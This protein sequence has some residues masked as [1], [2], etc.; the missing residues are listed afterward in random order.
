QASVVAHRAGAGHLLVVGAP[1]S[2]K[3]T[4]AV[5]TFVARA[6]AA[7]PPGPHPLSA[8][9]LFLAPSRRAGDRVHDAVGTRLA[10][11]ANR[12]LVRSVAAFAYAVVHARA[13]ALRQPPPTLVTG[14]QQDAVLAELLAGHA[15]GLGRDP[16]WPG[17]IGPQ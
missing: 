10:G 15:E 4:T 17:S 8:P 11:G 14:P 9:A 6:R 7:G 16:R 12:G 2:G 3:T 1:G 13:V 5:A